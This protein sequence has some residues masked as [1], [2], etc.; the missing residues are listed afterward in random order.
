MSL[1][2]SGVFSVN[3]SGQPV[4]SG[5]LITAAAFNALTA[6]IATALSTA[7]YKDGQ[8][9]ATANQPMGGYKHT[10]IANATARTEYAS[11]GQVQDGGMQ[12]LSSVSG[13]NTITA[14]ITPTPS[15]YAAGQRFSFIVGTTNTGAVTLNVSSLGAKSIKKRASGGKVDITAADLVAN[16]DAEVLYDGTDFVLETAR[17][18][19]H[20]ADIASAS[21]INLD[22]ATGDLVDVTGTTAITAI[23]LAEGEERT[24]RFTGILTLTHG[25]SLVLP[26]S[27]NITTAAGDF[28]IFRGYASGVV[29]CV[30]YSPL[31]GAAIASIPKS[32]VTTAGDTI[33]A[34]GAS[35]P[36]RLAIGTARQVLTVNA[37]ATAPAWANPITLGTPQASTSGTSIDFTGIPAGVR[38]ITI[39]FN[40]VSTNGTS[41]VIVQL[42]DAGGF[43]TTNYL[44]S[45]STA[46][47]SS[48]F[49][50]DGITNASAVRH[51]VMTLALEDSSDFTWVFG[52]MIGR[53]DSVGSFV[54]AGMKSLSEVLTQVRITTAGGVDTFDAG[55]IN[56]QYE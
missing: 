37:G 5:T 53:S 15:A 14:S 13:T 27:A 41:V 51:G 26:G 42:G 3:S 25:A 22:T 6:D 10:N 33:Y 52:S 36:A 19:S 23:T 31:T 47:F 49:A 43:E 9:I 32:L 4:Q 56:I 30:S 44:G 24:V 12:F 39:M 50:P 54:S 2:G 21:T 34:T 16:T 28:A 45:N 18:Y 46:N 38:R 11:A 7:L 20:G 17:T 1:N 35:T 8:Q 29:R 48:G 40:G 55:E